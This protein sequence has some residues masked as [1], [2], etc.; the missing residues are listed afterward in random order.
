MLSD[1]A[2]FE[3]LSAGDMSAFDQLYDRF[4]RSLFGFIAAQLSDATEAEDILHETFM[5]VL[6]ERDKRAE[7]RSFRAWLFQVA[8]HLC[9]NRARLRKRADRAVE[10]LP[11]G[12]VM[13][14]APPAVD[15]VL[16]L[17]QVAYRLQRAVT[18]L[19]RGLAEVYRLRAA[20]MSYDEVAAVLSVPVGTVKSRMHEMVKRLKEEVEI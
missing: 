9:L 17:N 14:S 11:G 13:G 12:A 18:R 16:E 5:A 10:G 2:L 8:H 1:D 3:R 19:P 15:R 4:A 20:G 6:R 7:V